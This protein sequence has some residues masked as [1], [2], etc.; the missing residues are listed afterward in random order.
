MLTR[1]FSLLTVKWYSKEDHVLVAL[2][3][4]CSICLRRPST[5]SI[6]FRSISAN[7]AALSRAYLSEIAF[8]APKLIIVHF[9]SI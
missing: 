2:S 6:P 7:L 4:C 9:L 3:F 1:R 8:T 5:G